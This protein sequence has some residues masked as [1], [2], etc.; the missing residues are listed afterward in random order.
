VRRVHEALADFPGE[1][2][3]FWAKVDQC[4]GLLQTQS[5]LPALAPSDRR[6]LL[7]VYDRPQISL[8]RLLLRM[9]PIH[10]DAHL[11]NVFI[12]SMPPFAQWPTWTG[13][14]SLTLRRLS[15]SGTAASEISI[16]TQKASM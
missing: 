8:D 14:P 10:G 13:P 9:A 5:A 3:N 15:A 4:R 11:G 2:P 6:F 16:S 7:Q 12:T 1:F